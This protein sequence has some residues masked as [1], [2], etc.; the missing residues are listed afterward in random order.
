MKSIS[1]RLLLLNAFLIVFNLEGIGQIN[2]E[3]LAYYPGDYDALNA[4]LRKELVYP[5]HELKKG[6]TGTVLVQF[7]IDSLGHTANHKI[8][9]S[10]SSPGLDEEAMRVARL[11]D[12]FVPAKAEGKPVSSEFVLPIKFEIPVESVSK[13]KS[14]KSGKK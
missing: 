7:T 6:I 14:K 13:G 10:A 11:I 12:G 8:Y 2:F 5:K 4:F 9:L 3:A 1:S